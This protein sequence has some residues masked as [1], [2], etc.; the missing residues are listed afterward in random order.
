[1]GKRGKMINKYLNYLQE[2]FFSSSPK[3]KA[4]KELKKRLEEIKKTCSEEMAMAKASGNPAWV[5]RQEK[6]CKG[7]V[8]KAHQEYQEKIKNL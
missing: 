3:E 1:M 6:W 5:E 4:E 8:E 7:W 2:G